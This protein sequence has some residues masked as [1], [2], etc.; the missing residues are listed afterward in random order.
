ME[1]INVRHKH[2]PQGCRRIAAGTINRDL[3]V[4]RRILNLC[5]RLWRDEGSTLTCLAEASLIQLLENKRAHK[6]YLLDW[7][8]QKLLF[9]E[10]TPHLERPSLFKVNS[11]MREKVT[12]C[13]QI[14]RLERCGHAVFLSP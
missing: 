7:A 5:A 2:P 9:S 13:E 3:A 6:P 4:A 1:Y 10:L 11:C 14:R 12:R 8:E